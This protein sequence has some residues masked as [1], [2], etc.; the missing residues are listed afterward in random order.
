MEIKA[1]VKSISRLKD[2]FFIVPDY[3][4]EYVWKP[5]DQVEQFLIDIDNEYDIDIIKQKSYFIGSII[6]VENAE[7][8]DVI[9]G[10]QRLTT[11]VITLCVLRNILESKRNNLDDKQVK[12]LQNIT[13]LL[14]DFDMESDQTQLRL[15]LQYEESRGFL[16][17]LIN[18]IDFKEEKTDSIKRMDEAYLKIYSHLEMYL[19]ESLE[20]L[21]SYARY[22]LTKIELVVIESENLSSALKIFETINQRGASLNAMDLVKNLLFSQAKSSDFMLI[23]DIW[24]EITFNLQKCGEGGSPL[25]FLRYF[26]MSRYYDGILREDDI[27]KWFISEQGKADT[28]YESNPIDFAKELRKLSKRYSDL[29]IATELI[30]DG[31]D[32][33]SVTNIGFINKYKSRQHLILLLAL[34]KDVSKDSIEYLGKQIE[35]YFFFS[36]SLGIQAKNNENQFS[37]WAIR[38]RN[39][40]TIQE[41]AEVV[42]ESIV[43]YIKEKLSE[44]KVKFRNIN[45]SHYNPL[46]RQR[47]VLGMIENTILQKSNLPVK[48]KDFLYNLQIEHILPQTPKNGVLANEFIDKSDYEEYVYKLGNVTLVESMIN[49]AVNNFNDLSEDWFDKKQVEYAKSSIISTNLLNDKFQIGL[50]TALNR[51]KNDYDFEFKEWDKESIKKRQDKLLDLAFDT[52]MFNFKRIDI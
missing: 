21:V 34:D 10:Q 14:S 50:H 7:K 45:H 35:S 9:D 26:V 31:G 3:Q 17:N 39:K 27:Y 13:E 29:V 1:E 41:I 24:K 33:P 12:Y 47:Y 5:D 40:S 11:I 44:F 30:K 25:R 19:D 49:Q 4:R 28:N 16:E 32:Y 38:L 46:Y 52:W 15:E 43:P 6:V 23:K 8:F 36:N 22:F 37:K 51:F 48:G 42:N 2:Y 18:N 20:S